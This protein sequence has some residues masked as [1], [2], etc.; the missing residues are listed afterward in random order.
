[1][2]E[3]RNVCAQRHWTMLCVATVVVIAS[4]LLR[5]RDGDHLAPFGLSSLTLPPLCGSQA[6]FGVE[7]PG[8]GLTRSFVALARGDLTGSFRYHHLGWLM[9]LAVLVQF[10]YRACGLWEL[11][12]KIV[13]RRWPNW[14]GTALIA[15]LIGNWLGKLAGAW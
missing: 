13:E 9:A 11:R 5:F 1:M 2:C 15:L 4:L 12:S 7:C 10:P 6:I 14:F 8:C 3:S